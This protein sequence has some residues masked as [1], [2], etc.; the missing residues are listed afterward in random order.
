VDGDDGLAAQMGTMPVRLQL[1]GQ[2]FPSAWGV[3]L[4]VDPAY[5]GRGL[6]QQILLVW[7]QSREV[8]LG[9][10]IADIAYHLAT[11]HLSWR[12]ISPTYRHLKLLNARRALA[13]EFAH[14]V[15]SRAGAVAGEVLHRVLTRRT[16]SGGVD[17]EVRDPAAFGPEADALW[18]GIH[19][20]FA[21][22][23]IRDRAYLAWRYAQHP[24]HRYRSLHAWRDGH[25]V[26]CF[27]LRSTSDR[28]GRGVGQI[29]ELLADPA[30]E[31]TVTALVG[32]ATDLFRE[33]NADYLVTLVTDRGLQQRLGQHGFIR[34]RAPETRLIGE[35]GSLQVQPSRVLAS[36][37]WLITLG[38]ADTVIG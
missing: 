15:L 22:A 19:H 14:P 24:F 10:G 18:A 36:E 6:A 25:P 34:R 20:A 8:T 31:T 30:D 17:V 3:D 5:R 7:T 33:G 4:M 29:L 26:G 16:R 32:K 13:G 35:F 28:K 2:E 37:N 23:P 27:V 38:D 9:K 1:D 21:L 11:T 12:D